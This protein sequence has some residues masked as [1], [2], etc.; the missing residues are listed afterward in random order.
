MPDSVRVKLCNSAWDGLPDLS[1]SLR[2]RGRKGGRERERKRGRGRGRGRGGRE[3]EGGGGGREGERERERARERER[4]S[5]GGNVNGELKE[6]IN[7]KS[8]KEGEMKTQEQ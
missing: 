5:E 4:E 6:K 2:E 1:P 8:R 7:H 3:G